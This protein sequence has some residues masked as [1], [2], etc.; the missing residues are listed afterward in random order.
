VRGRDLKRE[1]VRGMEVENENKR[2][3]EL[4]IDKVRGMEEEN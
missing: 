1:K 4:E 2:R 3:R